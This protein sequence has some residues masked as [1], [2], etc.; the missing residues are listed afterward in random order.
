MFQGERFEPEN[1]AIIYTGKRGEGRGFM[2]LIA[3][4]PAEVRAVASKVPHYGKYSYLAFAAGRNR[5][6]GNWEAAAGP[7]HCNLD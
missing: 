6:K 7:L 2:A 1:Y 3:D 5:V 4:N